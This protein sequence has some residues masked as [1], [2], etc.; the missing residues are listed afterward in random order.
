[1]HFL[2]MGTRSWRKAGKR[3]VSPI[4]ATILLVAITVVLAAVLYVLVSGLTTGGAGSKPIGSAFAVGP[5]P[6]PGASRCTAVGG[7]CIGAADYTYT[8]MIASSSVTFGNVLF[9][10]KTSAGAVDSA[11]ADGG[12][13]ILNLT[14][15]VAAS[16]TVT[17]GSV[18]MAMPSGGFTTRGASGVCG[19]SGTS[20]WV[21]SPLTN[22]YTLVIDMG[23]TNPANHGL[24][25]TALGAAG[26]TGTTGELT[27]T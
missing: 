23:T 9:E 15:V 21:G 17:A 19:I 4:V 5:N 27:L 18:P 16:Y 1:M 25:F 12:F 3:A 11:T 13:T 7:G 8:L 14:G 22:L 26:Y 24:T 2:G 10:V 6:T 20:C